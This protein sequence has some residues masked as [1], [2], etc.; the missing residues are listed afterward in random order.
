M[1]LP[2]LAWSLPGKR[3]TPGDPIQ[4]QPPVPPDCKGG[5]RVIPF[6]R[7]PF[8]H[9]P[10][11]CAP[12]PGIRCMGKASGGT[13]FFVCSQTI[14][15]AQFQRP[16]RQ[17]QELTRPRA[18][19]GMPN[20]WISDSTAS[21]PRAIHK[22]PLPSETITV[23]PT[24]RSPDFAPCLALSGGFRNIRMA[25]SPPRVDA[26]QRVGQRGRWA[27]CATPGRMEFAEEAA[28]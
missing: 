17:K 10:T 4:S 18:P 12:A 27:G 19:I 3:Q 16:M 5:F 11:L 23:S 15:T 24:S 22:V 1:H 7:A 13:V 26:G 25:P 14:P 8:D 9:T 20:F 28:P 2:W 21:S 6:A